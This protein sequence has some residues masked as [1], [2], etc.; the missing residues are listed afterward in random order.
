MADAIEAIGLE[1]TTRMLTGVVNRLNED[2]AGAQKPIDLAL[3]AAYRERWHRWRGY[4]V[5]SGQLRA[6]FT[7][8]G[9]QGAVRRAHGGM[10]EFG[11][12]LEYARYHSKPL[13]KTTPTM[14][15][16][17]SQILVDFFAGDERDPD[18]HVPR[19]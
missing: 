3:N 8:D 1:E 6:S 13:L 12:D 15:V 7:S 2:V 5:D 16:V 17:L 19:V 14:N 18:P 11:S 4:L 9:A 10:I